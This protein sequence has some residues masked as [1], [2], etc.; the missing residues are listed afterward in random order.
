VAKTF[1]LPVV[2]TRQRRQRHEANH[3]RELLG[4][5]PPTE[6]STT[7]INAWGDVEFDEREGRAEDADHGG[8]WGQKACL[9]FP[10]LDAM[11]KG[12][13]VLPGGGYA[14]APRG[15]SV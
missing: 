10:A 12:Y 15:T 11:R 13:E 6:R 9:A 5:M 8:R 1:E 3:T 14:S 2:R 4:F 7:E